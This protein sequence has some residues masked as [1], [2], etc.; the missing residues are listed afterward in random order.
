MKKIV[1]IISVIVFSCLSAFAAKPWGLMQDLVEDTSFSAFAI[2][3][4]ID[5]RPIRFAVSD[6]ISEEE[7][8]IF[9]ANIR[10][11]PREVLRQIKEQAV[12]KSLAIYCHIWNILK[13]NPLYSRSR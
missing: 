4:L 9:V 7:T 3:N 11:W 8:S 2:D 12:R 13:A 10:T 5:K 1:L 6:K